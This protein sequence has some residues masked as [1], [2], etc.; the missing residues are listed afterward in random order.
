MH[1]LNL[2]WLANESRPDGS[3]SSTGI[4]S[5]TFGTILF[6]WI[7]YLAINF[8]I[9]AIQTSFTDPS[10]GTVTNATGYH[11]TRGTQ[12]ALGWAFYIFL[13]VL[14]YKTRV[15]IRNKY[16]IRE[17]NCQNCEDCCCVFWCS[18]CTVAQ[19]ARHTADYETYA[20]RCCSET[21][22]P[23]NVQLTDETATVPL[24]GSVV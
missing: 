1:R 19:I 23:H 4:C 2:T 6:I 10:T 3:R 14:L 16:S 15:F 5:G 24:A 22:L 12:A 8:I 18:C 13:F 21:G 9:S 7:A 20:A 11:A 17:R